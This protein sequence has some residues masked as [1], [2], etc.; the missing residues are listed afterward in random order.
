MYRL[1]GSNSSE[2]RMNSR[3][4]M[5]YKRLTANLFA[6]TDGLAFNKYIIDKMLVRIYTYA[7]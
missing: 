5:D 7:S 6:G 3:L 2:P 1:R 4:N